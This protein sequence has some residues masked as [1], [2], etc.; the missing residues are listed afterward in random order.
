MV[1]PGAPVELTPEQ[2]FAASLRGRLVTRDSPD[3]EQIRASWNAE[4]KK[5]PKYIVQARTNTDVIAA[6]KFAQANDLEV[7]ARC[8][9]HSLR[10]LV[11]DG[12]VIDLRQMSM[13]RVEADKK[14]VHVG[15]GAQLGDVD[16]ELSLH[17]LVVPAGIVSDTGVGGLALVGGVGWMAR[18]Y[19]L[20]CDNIIG[21]DVV[22]AEGKLIRVTADNEY[23]DLFWGMKGAGTAFGIVT[24]FT[25]KAHEFGAGAAT[26]FGGA[27]IFPFPRAQEIL[28]K[29]NEFTKTMPDALALYAVCVNAPPGPVVILEFC[30]NGKEEDGRPLVQPLID[31]GP[32][33][34][35]GVGTVPWT[36]WQRAKDTLAPHGGNYYEAGL[37]LNELSE[38]LIKTLTEA[39]AKSPSSKNLFMIESNG[40]A[41]AR[42]PVESA[43]IAW[44]HAAFTVAFISAWA[45]DSEAE[46]NKAWLRE[47]RTSLVPFHTG[48]LYAN[49]SSEGTAVESYGQQMLARLVELKQKYDPT[50]FFHVTTFGNLIA[51]KK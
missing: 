6:I 40:G 50:N 16:A 27:L 18:S 35:V 19:G 39:Y 51:P 30:Y 4:L 9:G 1:H 7:T 29:F 2:A 5:H 23:K 20:T 44:R 28:T 14:I 41:R 11:D 15:G 37:N 31:L 24:S 34:Q 32:I 8:G 22:T 48:T 13:V 47:T 25:F 38:G 26:V 17:N 49:F 43:A 12:L 45:E 33:M 3:Y 42:V 46:A 10:C 36:T 21:L